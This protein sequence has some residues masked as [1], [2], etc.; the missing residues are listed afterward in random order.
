[1][2]KSFNRLCVLIVC[3]MFPLAGCEDERTAVVVES[4]TINASSLEM[5]V[6]DT[7]QLTASSEPESDAG[8]EWVSDNVGVVTVNASGLVTAI[9]EGEAVI[10]V[11][12]GTASAVCSVS[13]NTARP[14]IE[15]VLIKSGTFTMGSSEDETER[16]EFEVQHEVTISQDFYMGRYEVTNG[17]FSQFLNAHD[18]RQDG[19]L[20]TEEYGEQVMITEFDG[21]G[22]VWDAATQKWQPV[23]GMDDHP[24][25]NVTWYGAMEFAHWVGGTLPTE[26]QWE[27]ACRAGSGDKWYFGND[28]SLLVDHAWY[29]ENS[30]SYELEIK[31]RKVGLLLPNSWGLYDVYGNVWEWCLDTWN[32]SSPYDAEAVTDPVSP[33]PGLSNVMRG[34]SWSVGTRYSRSAYRGTGY[35]YYSGSDV[36]FRII[37]TIN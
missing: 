7:F 8:F 34:G 18:V 13:V 21:W 27:Y 2:K 29:W 4:I 32:G 16:T 1:M 33:H 6:G 19:I 9:A 15:M 30:S 25:V 14:E 26:A 3:A 28:A 12:A 24:V 37:K 31:T 11:S 5:T 22:S 10:S 35:P 36:G 20:L 23:E 17:Q